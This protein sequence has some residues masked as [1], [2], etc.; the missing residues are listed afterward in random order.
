M[1][2][3]ARTDDNQQ[4]IVKQLRQLGCSVAI[5]SMI[6]KGFPDFVVGYQNKNY[7]IELKDGAKTK[8]QKGLTMDEAKFF[9]AW[10]GQVDKCESLEEICKVIGII[11]F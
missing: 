8:S 3:I 2:R 6:G 10:K 1:R 11:L 4:L 7:L 9:T 5:T